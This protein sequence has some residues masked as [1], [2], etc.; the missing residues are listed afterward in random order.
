MQTPLRRSARL[1]A[2][3]NGVDDRLYPHEPQLPNS[4]IGKR[5]STLREIDTDGDLG[6]DNLAIRAVNTLIECDGAVKVDIGHDELR[7]A[8]TDLSSSSPYIQSSPS[9]FSSAIGPLIK[10]VTALPTMIYVP[11]CLCT[12]PDV[13][14]WQAQ[15]AG[16]N[17]GYRTCNNFYDAFMS[18]FYWHNE[19]MNIWIHYGGSVMLAF[20]AHHF[21]NLIWQQFTYSPHPFWEKTFL[22]CCILMGQVFPILFSAL[23]HHFYCVSKVWHIRCWY[24]DFFGILSGITWGALSFLYLAFYSTTTLMVTFMV[25]V[26]SGHL[27]ALYHCWVRFSRRANVEPLQPRD[28]MPEFSFVLSSFSALCYISTVI[29]TLYFHANDYL[30]HPDLFEV[31]TKSCMYPAGMALGIV[32]FAQGHIPER[33]TGI[34][35]LSDHFFDYFGHSHQWWHIVSFTLLYLWIE[36]IYK[37]YKARMDIIDM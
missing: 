6:K 14:I 3:G 7:N 11:P 19:S 9:I 28:R 21:G 23:C 33:F 32:I 35:G 25:V 24:L 10:P 1:L 20:R 17:N 22:I 5:K 12:I 4:T 26:V 37:H 29:P 27:Y 15:L 34:F 13:P 36:V 31:A 8:I 30:S 2:K 16:I 18:L